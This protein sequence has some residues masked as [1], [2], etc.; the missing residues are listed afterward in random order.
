[1]NRIAF[2]LLVALVV[3]AAARADLMPSFS[4]GRCETAAT[5][6]VVVNTNG[7][8]LESW[9]GDLTPGDLLPIKEFHLPTSE[10]VSE[11]G[12]GG[13]PG[14]AT[15]FE[16]NRKGG[17]PEKV[18]GARRV[19]F[20]IRGMPV[21][22]RGHAVGSWAPAHWVGDFNVSAV[23]LED[24]HAFALEQI[25]NPGSQMMS[26]VSTEAEFKKRVE[27]INK[28]VANLLADARA[29]KSLAAR[30]KILVGIVRQYPG[31]SPAAF[32]GL[33]WCGADA[34]APMRALFGEKARTGDPEIFG[35]YA[36]L[37]K[38]GPRPATTS[39]GNWTRNSP[40][41]SSWH[42]RSNGRGSSNT[43]SRGCTGC[44]W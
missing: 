44:C 5:H 6:I 25:F 3:P 28:T 29:E 21:H 26:Y 24:G 33:E 7:Q 36:T 41:G 4:S 2:A 34:V 1:M 30:A 42:S 32:A 31:F 22:N 38:I 10:T 15:G 20:L 23:W 39:C 43:T 18:T 11:F 27:G 17:V 8:V 40:P 16:T 12:R 19:L 35:A 13:T 37:A 14:K 9:R